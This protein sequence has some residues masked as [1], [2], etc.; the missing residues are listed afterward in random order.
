MT[1]IFSD[2]SQT[3]FF[4]VKMIEIH[5]YHKCNLKEVNIQVVYVRKN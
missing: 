3:S 5:L 1:H 4:R 2:Y